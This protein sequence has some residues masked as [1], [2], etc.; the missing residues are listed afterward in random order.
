[1]VFIDGGYLRKQ[2][3]DFFGDDSI[4]YDLLID[5]LRRD[6][7]YGPRFPQLVR[8][9]YYDALPDPSEPGYQKQEEYIRKVKDND[10]VEARLGRVK[11]SQEGARQKGVD[12]L[13]AID[14]LSKAYEDHF[15]VAV[16]L[17]GDDD[18]LD[19]VR[20]VKNAGK[21]IYGAFFP[22]HIARTL[23]DEFDRR[24]FLKKESLAQMRP[25][26]SGQVTT[27]R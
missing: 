21:Q 22:E 2:L 16:L 26:A 7:M 8:A 9:Y 6:T 18:F 23:Q 5:V 14:M 13:I 19:L 10:F 3:R 17:A 20:A 25:G 12:A 1:M 15:D 4:N 27:L 11:R 24:L